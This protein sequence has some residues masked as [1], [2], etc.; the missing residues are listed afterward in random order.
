MNRT[1]ITATFENL[2]DELAGL[3]AEV[4]ES[5]VRAVQCGKVTIGPGREC[6]ERASNDMGRL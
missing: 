5:L 6:D 3:V 1:S 4:L 2:D